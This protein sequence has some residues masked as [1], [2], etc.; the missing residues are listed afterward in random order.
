MTFQRTAPPLCSSSCWQ[1][2]VFG[3]AAAEVSISG[4]VT[5]PEQEPYVERGLLVLFSLPLPCVRLELDGVSD[6]NLHDLE[7][8]M[9]VIVADAADHQRSDQSVF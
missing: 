9:G 3:D 1:F 8:G 4:Y 7:I 6:M 2:E 5:M